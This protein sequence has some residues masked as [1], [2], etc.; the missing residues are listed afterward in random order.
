MGFCF[1][2][3]DYTFLD[4]V[5]PYLNKWTHFMFTYKNFT[6]YVYIN[7]VFM[8]SRKAGNNL[9]I[10]ENSNLIFYNDPAQLN[11][12]R[13]YDE[14]LSDKEIKEIYKTLILHYKLN[15]PI[16]I[17]DFS[18][19]GRNA[20]S[21]GY[22]TDYPNSPVYDNCIRFQAGT[23]YITIPTIDFS[24]FADNFTIA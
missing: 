24:G 15:N 20:T 3:D 21:A 10:A 1:Y 5:S 2:S 14:C 4:D 8:G 9:N 13:I 7:G 18:G 6:Q 11:D 17:K 22:L 23:P 16:V 19:Y 12:F